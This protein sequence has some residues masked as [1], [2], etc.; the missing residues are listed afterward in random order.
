[1]PAFFIA[2]SA[3]SRHLSIKS[4]LRQKAFCRKAADFG[5]NCDIFFYRLCIFKYL[6]FFDKYLLTFGIY[7]GM[8]KPVKR[9]GGIFMNQ[10]AL[11]GVLKVITVCAAICFAVVFFYLIPLFGRGIAAEYPEY[12]TRYIYWLVFM[13]IFSLPCFAALFFGW[14]IAVNIGRDNS[15]SYDNAKYLG[16]I[17]VLAGADSAFFFIGNIVLLCINMSH[18][19]VVLLSLFATFAGTAI[20]AI[21]AAL[22]HLVQKAAAIKAE[23]DL[24]I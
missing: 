12:Q 13:T 21:C 8:I 3:A 10:K 4:P 7:Y 1:M 11:S 5:I 22:S 2:K 16:T 6:S 9:F 19:G 23:N 17:S 18:P 24:T 14:K 15:F 20:C